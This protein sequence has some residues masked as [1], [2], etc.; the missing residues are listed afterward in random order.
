MMLLKLTKNVMVKIIASIIVYGKK[1][2]SPSHSRL[3]TFSSERAPVRDLE[4]PYPPELVEEEWNLGFQDLNF[5]VK[6]P[7]VE[8]RTT[9]LHVGGSHHPSCSFPGDY[10]TSSIR[11]CT[12]HFHGSIPM[13][14]L[15]S[16]CGLQ[17]LGN[18]K[19][20]KDKKPKLIC[21]VRK[22]RQL[23]VERKFGCDANGPTLKIKRL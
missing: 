21:Y 7:L 4:T 17:T 19:E 22:Q 3:T 2:K 13:S 1:K 16:H 14:D 23:F 15:I 20:K 8:G 10:I 18:E 5:G 11:D 9:T 6:Q 12:E